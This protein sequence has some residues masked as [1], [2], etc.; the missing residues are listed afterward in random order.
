MIFWRGLFEFAICSWLWVVGP[1]ISRDCA[2]IRSS[3]PEAF[4]VLKSLGDHFLRKF[5]LAIFSRDGHF[6]TMFLSVIWGLKGGHTTLCVQGILGSGKTYCAS[7]LLIV[8]TTVLGLPTLL[9]AEPNLPLL[10][11]AATISDLLL[12]APEFTKDRYARILAYGVPPPNKKKLS[13]GC[14]PSPGSYYVSFFGGVYEHS[15]FVP[16]KMDVVDLFWVDRGK[17]LMML[18]KQ[19]FVRETNL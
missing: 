19:T 2:P 5:T 6:L 12:D 18:H 3:Y 15:N 10:T 4:E 1:L 17:C 16:A 9:T 11:A 13:L 7:M 8:L 14:E